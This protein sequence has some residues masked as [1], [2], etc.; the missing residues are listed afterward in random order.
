[1]EEKNRG[2]VSEV[3][4]GILASQGY[5]TVG[6]AAAHFGRSTMG[7]TRYAK[8]LE[9]GYVKVSGA[10]FIHMAM[11]RDYLNQLQAKKGAYNIA[12]GSKRKPDETKYVTKP[13]PGRPRDG[14]G[15]WDRM[16]AMIRSEVVSALADVVGGPKKEE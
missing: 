10:G 4:V 15:Y 13:G 11:M 1:M 8:R 16:R 3:A 6:E 5:A 2:K 7:L 12:R 14:E 9:K